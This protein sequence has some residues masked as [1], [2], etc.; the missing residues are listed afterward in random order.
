MC[1]NRQTLKVHARVHTDER[2]FACPAPDC[3]KAFRQRVHLRRHVRCHDT[4]RHFSCPVCG[5][6]FKF[7]SNLQRHKELHD[8]GSGP[9][10]PRRYRDN[11]G[12]LCNLCG[13]K[14]V[15]PAAFENHV[16]VHTNHRPFV[17]GVC[18]KGFKQKSHL[19]EHE[20][21]HSGQKPFKCVRCEL[22]FYNRSRFKLH[23]VMHLNEDVQNG[24]SPEVLDPEHRFPV[25][26]ICSKRFINASNLRLHQRRHS[27]AKPHACHLCSFRFKM[28]KSLDKHLASHHKEEQ[29]RLEAGEQLQQER[30][31]S[32]VRSAAGLPVAETGAE[33][34]VIILREEED[35][36]L[37][38]VPELQDASTD[39]RVV[40]V[41]LDESER[42]QVEHLMTANALD[43]KWMASQPMMVPDVAGGLAGEPPATSG[44]IIGCDAIHLSSSAFAVIRCSTC[45]RSDS[46]NTTWRRQ[47]LTH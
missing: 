38:Y 27:N 25:C 24:E 30:Q 41:V 7:E 28:A 2:P 22:T 32:Q 35:G 20:R 5:R 31:Q 1:C 9:L 16:R 29:Q 36:S 26:T 44:T 14:F 12:I 13:K 18:Q 45:F 23:Q 15:S 33:A 4:V 21:I 47:Q 39:G 19:T 10:R 42:K 34:A 37:T 11:K 17:C 3:G 8:K 46:S 43:D 6:S 40:Q